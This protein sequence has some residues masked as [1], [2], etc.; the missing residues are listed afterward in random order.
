MEDIT[1]ECRIT[2]MDVKLQNAESK[3]ERKRL[4]KKFKEEE[5]DSL[6]PDGIVNFLLQNSPSAQVEYMVCSFLPSLFQTFSF[7]K[8]FCMQINYY[9]QN[10]IKSCITDI[11]CKCAS[12]ITYRTIL[13]CKCK[14]KSLC[15]PYYFLY[16][17]FDF[18]FL[19]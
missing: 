17:S 13:N 12:K 16:D 7:P 5:S 4:R 8:S 18:L 14:F 6:I 19:T 1:I 11:N 15:W 2:L 9:S 3:K 10:K